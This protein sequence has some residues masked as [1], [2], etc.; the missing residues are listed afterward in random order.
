[1][2]YHQRQKPDNMV[3]VLNDRLRQ[4]FLGGKIMLTCGVAALDE[5]EKARVLSALRAF[6]SFNQDNDPYGEHDCATFTVGDQTYIFKIDYYDENMEFG[7]EDPSD[8]TKT[9]RVLTLML[10]EEY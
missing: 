10:A 8:A 6:N 7:S 4:F 2:S 1:M 9:T 5:E 3:R